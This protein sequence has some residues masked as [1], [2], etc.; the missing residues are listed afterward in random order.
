MPTYVKQLKHLSL[1]YTKLNV[2]KVAVVV[3]A[4]RDNVQKHALD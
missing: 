4:S 1:A 3:V 2:M